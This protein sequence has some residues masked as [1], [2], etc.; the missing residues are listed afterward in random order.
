MEFSDKQHS[1]YSQ[2]KRISCYQG[3]LVNQAQNSQG[4]TA[5]LIEL[6]TADIIDLAKS[7]SVLSV[8]NA[9][10]EMKLGRHAKTLQGV[11]TTE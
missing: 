6:A 10:Y 7:F 1:I 2:V 3:E 8:M 11:L 4:I 9:G 5:D